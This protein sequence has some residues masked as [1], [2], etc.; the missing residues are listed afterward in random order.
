MTV[1][2]VDIHYLGSVTSDNKIKPSLPRIFIHT[3]IP[4]G[5]P[6]FTRLYI[7]ITSLTHQTK[8]GLLSFIGL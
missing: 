6:T 8:F 7:N 2:L 5:E 3:L 1:T 4:T